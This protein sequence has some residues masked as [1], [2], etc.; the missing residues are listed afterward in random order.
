[1]RSIVATLSI[2]TTV[3]AP[4]CVRQVEPAPEP[5]LHATANVLVGQLVLPPG[6]GSR[7]VEVVVTSGG[8]EGYPTWELFDDEGRFAHSFDV[9]PREVSVSTGLG[10]D[11]LNIAIDDATAVNASG[12][13]DL[14]ELDLRDTLA[15]H[16][17]VVRASDGAA[18]GAAR[19]ALCFGLPPVG[20]SGEPVAL[21]SRQFP[22]FTLGDERH[23]LI[24]H[25][26]DAIYFL[27]ERGTGTDR[28]WRSGSQQLFGPFTSSAIPGELLVD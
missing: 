13:L 23:W 4:S 20:P 18:P 16:A 6:S 21:G 3:F 9:R 17:M 14:G 10:P 22:P 15:S 11:L 27:V 12:E 1:M 2:L 5:A 19:M 25:D 26:T 24:P 28:E 8:A 7:G